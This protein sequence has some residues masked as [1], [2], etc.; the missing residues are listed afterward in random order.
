MGKSL[1]FECEAGISGDMAVAAMLD[2]GADKEILRKVLRSL[3]LEGYEIEIRRVLKSGIDCC[4]FNVKLDKSNYDHDMDYL[5]GNFHDHHDIHH[6]NHHDYHDHHHHSAHEHRHLA[7]INSIIDSAEMT[8]GARHLAKKIFSIIAKAEAEAHGKP[9]D[10]VGFHEV[11]A[12]DS[13][14]DIVSFAVCFDNLG[15]EKVYIPKLSE[16]TGTVRCQH[17]IMSVPVP[18]VLNIMKRS[19]ISLEITNCEGEFITPTGAAIAKAIA[20]DYE[21]P[22]A[23][24]IREV[25]LGAGKRKYD[26]PSIL[27]VLIIDDENQISAQT[28]VDVQPLSNGI[29]KLE[30]NID[31]ATGEVLAYT[32][33]RL[34]EA[35]ARDAYFVPCYMKK[36]RPGVILS[37]I[38]DEDKIKELERIIFL[39]TTTIGIRKIPFERSVLNRR[40]EDIDTLYGRAMVKVCTYEDKTFVY[41]EY[42]SVADLSKKSDISISEMFEIIKDAYI[43]KQ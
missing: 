7:E 16:G 38:C 20:T 41:P 2:L 22:K 15:I 35:G 42:D 19:N 17:G 29:Y 28:G 37:V 14:V 21:L 31:D 3:P 5:H 32:V 27:R 25:G 36:N 10:K 30:A 6:H 9:V 4:D 39:E 26:K 43:N 12:V 23:V 33:E 24:R 8:E 11:G 34:F 1:Y 13:I 18:A 40:M